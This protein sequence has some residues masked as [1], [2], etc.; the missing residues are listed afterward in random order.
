MKKAVLID[1]S[2]AILLFKSNWMAPLMDHYRVGAGPKVFEELTVTGR[3]GSGEFVRWQQEERLV[4]HTP[5][6]SA[7]ET[8][9]NLKRLGPGERECI[10]LYQAGAAAFIIIDDGPAAAFCRQS[11]IPYVNALLIPR[12]LDP[13]PANDG[14]GVADAVR[15]ISA[16]G[17]YAPWV[18]EYALTCHP[19]ALAFF[20]P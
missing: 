2:S 7:A 9:D 14:S 16:G 6:G 20:R 17:R 12:L 3:P 18:L 13:H 5:K 4:L 19:D 8:A 10:A 15:A 11:A 1:T